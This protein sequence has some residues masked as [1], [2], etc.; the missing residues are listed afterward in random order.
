MFVGKDTIEIYDKVTFS[1]LYF[2]LTDLVTAGGMIE[3][4]IRS[5]F[6]KGQII[7]IL[8]FE[9]YKFCH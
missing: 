9:R 2:E 1:A 3:D 5:R 4:E 8:S 7:H 6:I